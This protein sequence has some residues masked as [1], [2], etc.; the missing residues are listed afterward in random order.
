MASVKRTDVV[1]DDLWANYTES[2]KAAFAISEQIN[3]ELI[4]LSQSTLN[5]AKAFDGSAKSQRELIRAEKESAI[6]TKEKIKN[7]QELQKLAQQLEKTKQAKLKTE[8][9]ERKEAERL[10]K[11][12][13]KVETEYQKQSK[14]LNQLRNDYKNL[15]L[16]QG[17]ETAETRKMLTEI[18]RLDRTLKNVDAR[19][20]QFQRSVGN[21]AIATSRAAQVTRSFLSA[22]GLVGG[23]QLFARGVRDAVGIIRSFDE[24]MTNLSA[25]SGKSA[26]ELEP[27]KKQALD[28]GATTQYTASQIGELQIELAKLGFTVTEISQST[29]PI[30]N[31][32]TATGANLA[33]A[34]ALAGA[35]LRAFGLDAS[36]MNR[37]TSVLAVATTKTAL[38]F[39]F[40]NTAMSTIAPVAKAFGFS[41][42]DTT[43]LLGQLANSGFDASTAATATRNILLN[44]ADANGA[45]AKALGRPI[46]SADELGSALVE[47]RN[48]GIDLNTALQLTDKRSVAAFNTFLEGADSLSELK[49]SI[50]GVEDELDAMAA[51]KLDSIAGATDLLRSAWEG[52]ILEWSEGKGA[53]EGL[54]NVIL[55][56]ANNLKVIVKILIGG[57]K[58]W[59]A[60]RLQM[61]LFRRETDLAGNSIA[62]GLIPGLVNMVK[63]MRNTITALKAGTISAKAFGNA[64]KTIPWLA[65]ISGITTA[66]SLFSDFGDETEDLEN[67]TT[68]LDDAIKAIND[69]YIE[70]SAELKN[71]FLAL[72]DTTTG[73]KERQEVIDT[74]NNK[75]GT[76]LQNLEDETEF[77]NSVNEAYQQLLETLKEKVRFDVTQE[78]RLELVKQLVQ[79]EDDLARM[80]KERFDIAISQ[81]QDAI[82]LDDAEI[83]KK[84]E[85]YELNQLISGLDTGPFPEITGGGVGG[86]G[87][88]TKTKEDKSEA[89]LIRQRFA[90]L[91]AQNKLNL[92]AI[93]K[94]AREHGK[95]QEEIDA[96]IYANKIR[97]LQIENDFVKK[98]LGVMSEEYIKAN[99]DLIN[100][101]EDYIKHKSELIEK[102]N[103]EEQR[104][105]KERKEN[106][107]KDLRET[108]RQ[109]LEALEINLRA[110][111]RTEEQIREELSKKRLEQLKEEVDKML[112]LYGSSSP[113]FKEAYLNYLRALQDST[114]KTNKALEESF[115]RL[116]DAIKD[117]FDLAIK[118]QEQILE[119]IDRQIEAQEKLYNQSVSREQQLLDIAKERGLDASESIKKER[120]DQKAALIAQRDLENKKQKVEALIAA[121]QLLSAKIANGEGNP[122]ANVKT[123]IQNIKS[124]I[125]GAFFEGTETTIKNE[126]G[127]PHVKGKDGYFVRVDGR[128][129]VMK[130]SLSERIDPTITN[131]EV[132]N[133]HLAY[134]SLMTRNYID[135][136]TSGSGNNEK[137][138][139]DRAVVGKLVEVV[140]AIQE[141]QYG[142][143][144]FNAIT[145]ALQYKGNTKTLH[146]RMGRNRK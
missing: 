144:T 21:Y 105:E 48:K 46:T 11:A 91:Q 37:V 1:Q 68:A 18:Q 104:K 47:L 4:K 128:E 28:L 86:G 33:D 111:G 67:K 79:A 74:I 124:F 64:I 44:L 12:S 95:N 49:E 134:R 84:R 71:L 78:K 135:R 56:L 31:F 140:K 51:K 2:A 58:I 145:G 55:F 136:I 36:E 29:G 120:E 10:A 99:N 65:I 35:S 3:Q 125:D 93:E 106:E 25:I 139:T 27:L 96:E 70:E 113:E 90:D 23:I 6:L 60:Y 100:A 122:V 8:Q 24:A 110:L 77:V 62:R 40:L 32:A 89:D 115:K 54:K 82:E 17:K 119:S 53:A 5:V 81:G 20:G 34:A 41:I 98:H 146:F 76:T 57:I 38:S 103:E 97:H 63:N 132:V 141:K 143:T 7:D 15:I 92:Q 19:V 133:D 43:A 26:E 126:L 73:S 108:H 13:Q 61:M 131:E 69:R 127:S 83:A 45:L 52:L 123:D 30:A 109:N 116:R 59:I 66:I 22:L 14:R 137:V 94:Q 80:Q 102:A 118:R 121:L 85:I 112:E 117:V 9:Q 50:T 72:K 16:V 114:E 129:R 75:Y 42:E 138:K 142:E 101:T 87:T 39:D 107:I 130:P 88:G